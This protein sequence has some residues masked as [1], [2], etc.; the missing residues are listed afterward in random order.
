MVRI[1]SILD[2]TENGNRF[3]FAGLVN[4]HGL[5]TAF[6][7]G[8]FLDVLAVFLRGGGTDAVQ[9]TTGEFR[10]EHVAQV[11]GSFR[12]AR[13]HDSVDFIDEQQGIAVFFK[14]VQHGFQ[15]FLEITAVFCTR[16]QG[17]QIQRKQ[18][19]ALQGVGHIAAV[20]T[21]GKAFHNGGLTHARFTD[22]ARVVFRLSAKNQ[23]DAAD[24][25]FTANHRRKL[26]VGSHFHEFAAVQFQRRLFL[27]IGGTRK[28]VRQPSFHDFHAAQRVFKN[29]REST[30]T[31]ELHQGHEHVARSH[32]AVHLTRRLHRGAQN[33]VQV[34]IGF[35]VGVHALHTRNLLHERFQ[36]AAEFVR[37][38][39]LRLVEFLQG[40]IRAFDKP[41]RQMRRTQVGMRATVTQALRLGQHLFCIVIEIGHIFLSFLPLSRCKTRAKG[42]ARQ[43]TFQIAQKRQL[44]PS[45]AKNVAF[46]SIIFSK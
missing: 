27:G 24:F 23:D 7:G 16:H 37:L 2:A 28:R 3:L 36:L 8:I 4:L 46:F 30:V 19:L 29:L 5:E 1:K 38:R 35:H 45:K 33:A 44:P 42:I 9:L 18:L 13:T 22:Q 32:H 14:G 12:L 43:K 17:R 20:N 31:R 39:A 11:H 26:S 40:G 15:A 6:Q 41:H 34:V 10:L 21:L 25:L